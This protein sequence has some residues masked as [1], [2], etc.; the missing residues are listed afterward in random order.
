MTAGM[1]HA[2]APVAQVMT[3]NPVTGGGLVNVPSAPVAADVTALQGVASA[4]NLVAF[5]SQ[6]EALSGSDPTSQQLALSILND[7]RNVDMAL[8]GF[9]GGV[10][11]ILPANIAGGDQ[12][13]AQQMIAAAKG[14]SVDQAFSTLIVQAEANLVGQIDHLSTS[15]QDASIRAFASGLLPTVQADLAAA[16]GTGTLAPVGVAPSSATLDSTDLDTLSTYY[17]I[18]VMERFLGQMTLLVTNRSPIA[19]Y[20]AKLIGDHEGAALALGG[21]AAGTQTYLPA[22]IPS[23]AAPMAQSVVAGL[24]WVRPRNT[25]RYDRNYLNQ[26]VMGHAEALKLTSQVIATA[27]NP[28]LKQFAVNVQPTINM[29]LLA[30]RTLLRTVR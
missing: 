23:S 22:S 10:S 8:N 9:A 27:Q 2:A 30:A 21:Y 29:H 6:F 25:G 4:N 17:A 1:A 11:V 28:N 13:L 26:M 24:R 3:M 19:L 18:N 12:A 15:A 14:G 20:S 7:A 16:Q 5:L